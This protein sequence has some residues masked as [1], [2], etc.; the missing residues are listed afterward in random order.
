MPADRIGWSSCVGDPETG[1]VYAQGVCG[2]FCCLDGETGKVVWDHSLHEEFGL[3]STYG[4]RTNVPV[5][6]EDN[7][8]DQRRGRRLGRRAE[9]G[10]AS[11]G[12]PTASC[13]STKR[14]ASCAG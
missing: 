7:R 14:P 2:Y 12:P 8:A 3:I 6:F 13:A 10:P 4:G 9:V 1:R 5:I 11:P